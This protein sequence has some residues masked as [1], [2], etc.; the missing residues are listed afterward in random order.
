MILLLRKHSSSTA[1]STEHEPDQ[2]VSATGMSGQIRT[3]LQFLDRPRS[4]FLASQ[5]A[6]SGG[7]EVD[8]SGINERTF[9]TS[10]TKNPPALALS[11]RIRDPGEGEWSEVL[12]VGGWQGD[13]KFFV[14]FASL[15]SHPLLA[16]AETIW[17]VRNGAAK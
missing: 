3:R 13:R 17:R 5:I 16:L 6:F 12:R 9:I 8:M 7:D 4:A 2:C 15:V 10:L 11:K 14:C 1:P